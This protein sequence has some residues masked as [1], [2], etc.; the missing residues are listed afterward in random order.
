MSLIEPP[1]PDCTTHQD[2][3][4]AAAQFSR[5]RKFVTTIQMCNSDLAA[6][7]RNASALR[8]RG[9]A[10]RK[11]GQHED[12]IADFDA[13]L[14]LEPHN[15]LAL[16]GRGSAKRA[17]HMHTEGLTD[18]DTA[19]E[20]DPKSAKVLIGRS[21]ALRALGKDEEATVDLDT[22]ICME[23]YNSMALQLRGELSR[24][25]G[26]HPK[27]IA[28]FTMA[29]R[30]DRH[31]VAA[32]A[33]RGGAKRA[34]G[35]HEEAMADYNAALLLEPRNAS[36]LAGRGAA[37]LE[38]ANFQ[39]ASD[40]FQAA[41]M[42]DPKNNFATWGY[43]TATQELSRTRLQSITL[44]G[45]QRAELNTTYVQ[46]WQPE[47]AVNGHPTYWSSDGKFLVYWCQPEQRWKGSRTMDLPKLQSGG[48]LG[49]I[50]SPQGAD[51]FCPSFFKGWHEWDGLEWL[52]MAD[53][54][55]AS[56]GAVS[57]PLQTLTLTSFSESGMNVKYTERRHSGSII[58][59][60]ETYWSSDEQ[61]FIYWCKQEHRWKGCC[62]S[63]LDKINAG[64]T[65]G[66]ISS[67]QGE[68]ITLPSL[69]K[70]W[71]EWDGTEWTL[72]P[73]MGIANVGYVTGAR[74]HF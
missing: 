34:L 44:E 9:E 45:F 28:D 57:A 37:K 50:G 20:L 46:R 10:K 70:G 15:V 4:A 74:F 65:F 35:R 21:G 43:E 31:N 7:P 49:L 55:I 6:V 41:L 62:A 19:L 56:I 64:G 42:A 25:L 60:R 24:K 1:L 63:H 26:W 17:L 71:H 3:V 48:S 33:G 23:P 12:A 40:D 29:L 53:A 61:F 22:A 69:Y 52:L 27:A 73:S 39:G 72:R 66:N 59:G 30:V 47:F 16:A 2:Y 14:K 36:I 58:N 67:P 18:F 68:E 8:R 13:A 32:L 38:L 54:G 5:K 11:L 51:I